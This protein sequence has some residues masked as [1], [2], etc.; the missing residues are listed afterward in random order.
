MRQTARLVT[1]GNYK[2][3]YVNILGN[4]YPATLQS[5][6]EEMVNSGELDLSEEQP[7]ILVPNT[8]HPSVFGYEDEQQPYLDFLI[9]GVPVNQNIDREDLDIVKITGKVIYE[10]INHN[11][12]LVKLQK[13]RQD[14]KIKLVGKLNKSLTTDTN[15][16]VRG[17]A[18][19]TYYNIEAIVYGKQLIISNSWRIMRQPSVVNYPKVKVA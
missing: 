16:N 12:V 18:V 6:V 15:G 5:R 8:L 14:Q 10:N 2:D 3:G 19:D 13:G 11:F 4:R 9:I 17:T 7:L 1:I